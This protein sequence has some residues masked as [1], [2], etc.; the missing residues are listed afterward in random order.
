MSTNE[1]S[2]ATARTI[3]LSLFS[4]SD[5]FLNVSEVR[6]L[7]RYSA[8]TVRATLKELSESGAI[9]NLGYQHKRGYVYG[10]NSPVAT[11]LSLQFGDEFHSPRSLLA[12]MLSDDSCSPF[13]LVSEDNWRR[14]KLMVIQLLMSDGVRN[15][16]ASPEQ[17]RV[18]V[19]E[20]EEQARMIHRII[21]SLKSSDYYTP[22]ARELMARDLNVTG[23]ENSVDDFRRQVMGD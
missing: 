15:D 19:G 2:A 14:F 13:V 17:I 8:N 20:L 3:I 16:M 5:T 11:E 12:K 4:Q 1:E 6:K 22:V 7:T 18:R 21:A 10:S 9:T 23:V